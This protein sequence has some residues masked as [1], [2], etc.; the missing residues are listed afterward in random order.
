MHPTK[1]LPLF[2]VSG[3]SCAGKSTACEILFQKE[4]DYIVM[5]S[6]LIWN[7]IYDTPEDNYRQYR[8]IWM[9]MSAN[10]AQIGKPVVLCGCATPEQFENLPERELFTKI[11]YIAVV[12]DSDIF[13]KRMREGRK[14]TD[15]G[16]IKSSLHFNDWLKKNAEKTTPTIS[17]VDNS[18]LTPE[19]TAE[20]IDEWIRKNL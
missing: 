10:I 9:R 13:E 17:L 20:R 7:K 1:K 14:V 18:H 4:K 11:H 12:S 3:A 16:W 5:E 15:D 6:D 2:I 19:E 8:S